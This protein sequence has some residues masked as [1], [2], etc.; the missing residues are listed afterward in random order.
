MIIETERERVFVGLL[1]VRNGKKMLNAAS[2]TIMLYRGAG[3]FGAMECSF[4]E[5][6]LQFPYNQSI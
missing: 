1:L 6:K 5:Q 3:A 4:K 2:N